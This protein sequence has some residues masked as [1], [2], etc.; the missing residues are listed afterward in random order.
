VTTQDL[1][2]IQQRQEEIFKRFQIGQTLYRSLYV[3][4][5]YQFNQSQATQSLA[6]SFQA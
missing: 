5:V 2:N 4:K 1:A 6:F 3:V